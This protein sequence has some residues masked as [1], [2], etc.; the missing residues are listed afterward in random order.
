[1]LDTLRAGPPASEIFEAVDRA[2]DGGRVRF[3]NW[4]FKRAGELVERPVR[5]VN[6]G[7]FVVVPAGTGKAAEHGW[8]LRTH[9][10]IKGRAVDH[11][12]LAAFVT[13]LASQPVVKDVKVLATHAQQVAGRE[14]VGFDLAVVIGDR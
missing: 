11:S 13:R 12:A 3:L 8:R 7:Y 6:T 9:M 5:T 10:E 1:M 14:A 2:L 4:R